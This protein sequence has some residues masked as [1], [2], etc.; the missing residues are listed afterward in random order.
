MASCGEHGGDGSYNRR[1]LT[2]A[3][4]QWLTATPITGKL[5]VT[6]NSYTKGSAPDWG[7]RLKVCEFVLC[8][9]TDAIL[10]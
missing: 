4:E 8:S 5:H 2:Q 10:L 7:F 3:P 1:Q 9:K 6:F